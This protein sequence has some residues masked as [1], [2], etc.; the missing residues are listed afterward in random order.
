[1]ETSSSK[2]D[3]V[4]RIRAAYLEM[5]GLRLTV[6]QV[7]RLCG[8][9][10]T[11]CTVVLDSLVEAKFLSV[12]SDGA[13]TRLSDG[14]IHHSRPSKAGAGSHSIPQPVRDPVEDGRTAT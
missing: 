9:E 10:R 3:A 2:R 1:M 5:P 11:M 7:R 12:K 6:E 8:V 13:Y 14:E 4:E